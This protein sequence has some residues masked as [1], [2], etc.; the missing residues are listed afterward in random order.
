[1]VHDRYL[2]Y[3]L[4]GRHVEVMMPDRMGGERMEG[5]VER[6]CRDIF[7]DKIEVTLDGY[8]HAFQEPQAIV[9]EGVDIHFLYGDVDAASDDERV[10]LDDDFDSYRESI[11]QHIRRTQNCPVN[12][13]VFKLGDKSPNSHRQACCL[14]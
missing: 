5:V 1:M 9:S 7:Q 14:S 13:M 3:R 12:V 8:R 11:N 10:M 4:L 2:I 6:V